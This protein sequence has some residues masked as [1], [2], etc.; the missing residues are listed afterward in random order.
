MRCRESVQ[1]HLGRMR[2]AMSVQSPSGSLRCSSSRRDEPF[3]G[4]VS[5]A[6]ACRRS[7][8]WMCGLLPMT[9]WNALEWHVFHGTGYLTDLYLSLIHI[10]SS[11]HH[12]IN[13]FHAA[14]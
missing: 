2:P 9:R 8:S 7:A 14:S 1:F 5:R 12:D 13:L 11:S 6:Q 4:L 10:S 3:T